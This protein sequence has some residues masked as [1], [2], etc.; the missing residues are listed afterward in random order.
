[1][2]CRRCG[3]AQVP[4]AGGA[5]SWR[6]RLPASALSPGRRRPGCGRAWP[7]PAQAARGRAQG[8]G[9]KGEGGEGEWGRDPTPPRRDLRE[10]VRWE[11]W[12]ARAPLPPSSPLWE[13]VS[14]LPSLPPP[15]FSSL[16]PCR[17]PPPLPLVSLP[18]SGGSSSRFSRA[19]D[20]QRA[21]AAQQLRIRRPPRPQLPAPP[22]PLSPPR[23][24][25]APVSLL[26][27]RRCHRSA[28]PAAC[29]A[30]PSRAPG[31]RFPPRTGE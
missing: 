31:W 26:G 14:P 5:G 24:P 18:R 23:R 29:A 20:G 4:R 16:P 9:A 12:R 8:K 10:P 21:R 22:P 13:S 28:L 30:Q 19:G 15:P 7:P 11:P 27:Q 1:M 17:V 3:R 25:P 2:G 6:S